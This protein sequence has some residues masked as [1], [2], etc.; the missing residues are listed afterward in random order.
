MKISKDAQAIIA[1]ITKDEILEKFT[2]ETDKNLI[3]KVYCKLQN[4]S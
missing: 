2:Y 1:K 3:K 4:F